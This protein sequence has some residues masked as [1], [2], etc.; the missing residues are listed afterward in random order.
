MAGCFFL[1]LCNF[2]RTMGPTYNLLHCSVLAV[3]EW[4]L[5]EVWGNGTTLLLIV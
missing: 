1:T 5:E 4:G 3:V 2:E